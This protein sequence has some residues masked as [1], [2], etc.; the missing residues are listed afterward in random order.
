VLNLIASVGAALMFVGVVL[1]I[2]N[3]IVSSIAREP[4]GGNPWDGYSLE[5]A[6][7]SPPPEFNFTELPP[8]R[9]ERPV[10]DLNHP[11]LAA[12]SAK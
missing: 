9:S 2:V 3:V 5:W 4:A 7:A 1:F 8:I 12:G 11:E 6:T 10:F